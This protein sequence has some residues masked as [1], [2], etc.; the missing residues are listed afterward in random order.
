MKSIFSL[1]IF[2]VLIKS[3]SAQSPDRKYTV[4]LFLGEDCKICQY[5]APLM[6][7]LDSLYASDSLSFVGLFPNR[8][9]SEKGIDDYRKKHRISFDLKREYYGTKTKAFEVTITPEVVVYNEQA[10]R[11]IYK[12]RIDN[13]YHKLGRRRQVVTTSELR[14][15]LTQISSGEEVTVEQVAPIGC[16]ITFR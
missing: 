6:N 12:G 9:S 13:S 8:Y 10:K 5:Y 1:L 7:E 2:L 3:A 4:Y 14:D 16:Y 15:V 11:I